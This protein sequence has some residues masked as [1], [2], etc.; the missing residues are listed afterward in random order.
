[1]LEHPD[2]FSRRKLAF[3]HR[4]KLEEKR[5]IKRG[6]NAHEIAFCCGVATDEA[7]DLLLVIVYLAKGEKILFADAQRKLA[8]RVAKH[9]GEIRLD[10]FQRIDAKPV[11]VELGNDIL[12]GTD[13]NIADWK[14]EPFLSI[15]LG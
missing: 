9:L 1:M 12:I 15:C 11:H 4:R 2:D 14:M 7:R 6:I 5:K 10:V 8:H 13:Q 3:G